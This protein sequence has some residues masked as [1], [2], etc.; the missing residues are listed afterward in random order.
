MRMQPVSIT[1]GPWARPDGVRLSPSTD[2]SDPSRVIQM[3]LVDLVTARP[4][5]SAP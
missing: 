1:A 3:T 4:N 5:P 2:S